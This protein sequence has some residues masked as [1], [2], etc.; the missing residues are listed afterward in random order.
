[1]RKFPINANFLIGNAAR[2]DDPFG[3]ATR[4][5]PIKQGALYFCID[6]ISIKPR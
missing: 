1:M 5:A 6:E 4:Q 2:L 3:Y